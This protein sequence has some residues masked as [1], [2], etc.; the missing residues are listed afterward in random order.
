MGPKS[1]VTGSDRYAAKTHKEYKNY[2]FVE[3][4]TKE[5]P[6]KRYQNYCKCRGQAK[7][8]HIDPIDWCFFI[9]RCIFH[10]FIIT[11]NL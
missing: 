11:L 8:Q 7:Q 6:V 2:P 10:R 3:V 1:V 5:I 9:H 4:V